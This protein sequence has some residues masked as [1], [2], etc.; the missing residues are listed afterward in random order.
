[1]VEI[2]SSPHVIAKINY[3][4]D[5]TTGG[6]GIPLA[7]SKTTFQRVGW[8][9]WCDGWSHSDSP[10]RENEEDKMIRGVKLSGTKSQFCCL[11]M[12]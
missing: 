2:L 8:K 9:E 5:K 10:H 4:C 6:S 11:Q 3:F 1:V 12:M 7:F